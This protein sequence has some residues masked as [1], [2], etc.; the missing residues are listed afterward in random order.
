MSLPIILRAEMTDNKLKADMDIAGIP[1]LTIHVTY[2][3]GGDLC[4][5]QIP[6]SGF[7]DY[8]TYTN[9]NNIKEPLYWH[10]FASAGGKWAG[11]V[12]GTKHTEP[13]TEVRPGS[14]G[15]E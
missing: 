11:T 3:G 12:N 15:E 13:S 4:G 10:S 6:N 14:T 7:E 9:H 5:Y 2:A 1:G 8:Y